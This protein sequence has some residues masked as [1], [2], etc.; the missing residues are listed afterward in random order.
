MG[1]G[2][3]CIQNS[4]NGKIYIGSAVDLK[5]RRRE[6]FSRLEKKIHN[7]RLLQRS[8]NK[9]GK[10]FFHFYVIEAVK[11]KKDLLTREQLYIDWFDVC[12][13]KLGYNIQM[14]AGSSLGAKRTKDQI[15]NRLKRMNVMPFYVC[16]SE[17]KILGEFINKAEA[18]EFIG[19]KK[20]SANV[21]EC[22]NWKKKTLNKKFCIYKHEIHRLKERVDFCKI[23]SS[24]EFYITDKDETF[25]EFFKNQT[26][27]AKKYNLN[28]K[29]INKV[30]RGETKTHK[31]YVFRYVGDLDE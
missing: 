6:H 21:I 16:S 11:E 22:L 20:S 1:S 30:L 10:S 12:N 25:K 5:R 4:K 19:I 27:C 8:Y 18:S 3:Y 14:I 7:N 24:K 2:I 26:E 23:L 29:G 13:T 17:G 31:G 15:L 9:Y 28:N